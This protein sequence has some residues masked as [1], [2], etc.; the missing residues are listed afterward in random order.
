MYKKTVKYED[1][2]G[3]ERTEDFY[4]NL[5]KSELVDMR[6][7]VDGGLEAYLERI[8]NASN[9]RE[10]VRNFRSILLASYGEKSDD[11][12]HFKKSPE[13]TRDFEN[14]AAFSSIILE[15]M[16]DSNSATTLINAIMPKD[17]LAEIESEA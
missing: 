4:F 15:F 5:T 8:I 16:T 6:F 14:H 13:I 7:S 9:E 11:G 17:L 10:I 2:N 12:R 3:V 1:F